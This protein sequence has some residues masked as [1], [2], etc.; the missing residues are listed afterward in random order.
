MADWINALRAH[1]GNNLLMVNSAGGW[2]EDDVGRVLLQNRSSTDEQWG[3]PGGILELGESY[4]EAAVRE[5]YEETGLETTVVGLIGVY[6]KYK[7]VLKNGDECQTITAIFR[8]RI[9]GGYLRP[10]YCETFGLRFFEK[11]DIPDLYSD[12]HRDVLSDV[13]SNNIPSFR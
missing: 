7:C 1:V 11:T 3:F 9:T 2:I 6:S 4:E 10:D 13:M 12:Q 8:M 5:V